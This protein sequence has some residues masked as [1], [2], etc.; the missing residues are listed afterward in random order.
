MRDGPRAVG[1]RRRSLLRRL[2]NAANLRHRAAKAS[3]GSAVTHA[4][5]A[6]NALARARDLCDD[7]E[8]ARWVR[9]NFEASLRTAQRYVRLARN[10]PRI[11]SD[12]TR[13]SPASQAEA[14][15]AIRRALFDSER[16]KANEQIAE[17]AAGVPGT[18]A[19]PQS[20]PIAAPPH[21]QPPRVAALA[22]SGLD[23]LAASLR[24]AINPGD[25][26]A[27]YIVTRIELL[28][29]D[30]RLDVYEGGAA[31]A[32]GQMVYFA[33]AMGTDRVK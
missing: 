8:W 18:R 25:A 9:R 28:S 27:A 15:R 5:A 32:R 23:R 19:A 3:A 33:E 31:E 22:V 14:A 29:A 11:D 24:E 13:V 30:I 7:G 17:P 26:A 4:V 1:A 6:G 10:W 16:Q 2:A 20:D 21:T 12:A